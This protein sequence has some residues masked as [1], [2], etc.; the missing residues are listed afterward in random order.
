MQSGKR[1]AGERKPV[2]IDEPSNVEHARSV[3]HQIGML[4]QPLVER[5]KFGAEFLRRGAGPFIGEAFPGGALPELDLDLL[6]AILGALHG[7][8]TARGITFERLSSLRRPGWRKHEPEAQG[9]QV[10]MEVVLVLEQRCDLV[11]VPGG[12]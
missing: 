9:A 7:A 12:N 10:Q 11:L 8:G 1:I 5:L 3:S 4:C 2:R 6:V